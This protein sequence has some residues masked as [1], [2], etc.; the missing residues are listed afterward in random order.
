LMPADEV[1]DYLPR[2]VDDLRSLEQVAKTWGVSMQAALMRARDLGV[3]TPDE[4]RRVM[5]RLS[6]A[7][8]RTREPIDIGPPERPE[9]LLAAVASLPEA[10]SD[11]AQLADGLGLPEGRL[12]RMLS[13]PEAHDDTYRGEVVQLHDVE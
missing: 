9:L 8:W 4:H 13:L 2:R 5:K 1:I 7:G 12:R 10:G 3:L 6:A 11:L